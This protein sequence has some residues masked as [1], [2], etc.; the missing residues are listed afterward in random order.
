MS[1]VAPKFFQSTDSGA[2]S[3][4]GTVGT[5]L[6]VLDACLIINKMFTA[7][8]GASFVDN[9]VEARLE[10][11]T[12][13]VMFQG[14]TANND[15]A[16]FGM[17]QPFDRLRFDFAAL[18]V[19]GTAITLAWEYWN[20]SAWT[21]FTPSGDTTSEFTANGS[22]TWSIASLTGW[23]TTT[24]N[25]ATLYWIRVRF[26]AGTWST[27]PTVNYV[28]ATGWTRAFSGT[29]QA[30]Y[31]MGAG[32]GFYIN[33]NDNGP[34]AGGAKEARLRG[35]ETM[36]AIDTGTGSFPTAA[37]LSAG[38]IARK[39]STA[40]GTARTWFVA[41]DDRSFTIGVISEGGGVVYLWYFG[42]IKSRG[43]SSDGFR[44]ALVGRAVENSNLGSNE[45]LFTTSGVSV[46]V[47]GHY[48]PRSY[49]G[50]GTSL[51]VGA[52]VP[53]QWYGSGNMIG[54]MQYPNGPDG[55]L[56]TD[57]IFLH[58]PANSTERGALRGIWAIRHAIANFNNAD[59]F[60]G[61]GADSGRTFRIIKTVSNNNAVCAIETSDTWDTD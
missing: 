12:A 24:V 6:D 16:H 37:Q 45:T 2:P 42:D 5:L 17:S 3:V 28:T 11:G 41:C 40:D 9:S 29:N 61:T 33:V 39:S 31:H 22:V 38:D 44:V 1:V 51:Q 47:G 48:M 58:E 36:S 52:S 57:R 7:V 23:A 32:N 34:G 8:S 14:P 30:A 46:A 21:A 25:S 54:L 43:G 15:E 27:N 4:S 10:G 50:S 18:G 60:Q 56:Y 13:F 35:Y 59:V 26:T 55:A 49:T 19:Q 20:G 53:S